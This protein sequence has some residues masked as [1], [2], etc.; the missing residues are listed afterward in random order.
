MIWNWSSLLTLG[1]DLRSYLGA[2]ASLRVLG[3]LNE[4]FLRT[5]RGF[6]ERRPA[7]AAVAVL[8]A[9]A[10]APPCGD[11]CYHKSARPN[12]PQCSPMQRR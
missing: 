8:V 3:R 1:A 12:I 5:V 7:F 11:S 9:L 10:A 2:R 6:L 4:V